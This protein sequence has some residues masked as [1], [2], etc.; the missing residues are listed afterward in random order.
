MILAPALPALL[1]LLAAP[2]VAEIYFEQSTLVRVEGEAA[3]AA[4]NSR[5]YHAGR[6]MRLEAGDAPGGPALLLRLDRGEAF[7][8][9]PD[10][11]L[12]TALDADRLRAR[13]QMDASLAGDLM[14]NLEEGRVRS[15]PL[16]GERTIAGY[17]CRGF[18]ITAPAV[19]LELWVSDGLPLG[20][21]AFAELVEWSGAGQSLGA[22]LDEMRKLPGFPLETR[23]RVA[24]LGKTQETVST[25]T[26]VRV[27]PQPAELFEVPEG[28]KVV[29]EP[30][31]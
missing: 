25:I 5:V 3:G 10:E 18:R 12:A 7:R 13:S 9:D 26:R 30:S 15:Q 27:G 28:W 4:V 24:V 23:A 19:V 8:L 1:A 17:T 16:P 20:V 6:R 21:D 11:R 29:A 2:A 22:L 14:G 31:P